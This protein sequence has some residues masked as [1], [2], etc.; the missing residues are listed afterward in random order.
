MRLES[1]SEAIALVRAIVRISRTRDECTDGFPPALTET[2]REARVSIE[3]AAES[4][5]RFAERYGPCGSMRRR[6]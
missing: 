1:L 6:L 3:A 5:R 4:R 2:I